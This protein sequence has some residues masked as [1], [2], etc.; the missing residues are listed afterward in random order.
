MSEK[1]RLDRL[2][3][4]DSTLHIVAYNIVYIIYTCPEAVNTVRILFILFILSCREIKSRIALSRSTISLEMNRVKQQ[5][6]SI[7]VEVAF[8]GTG[9]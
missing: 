4:T 9:L 3:R 7:Y 8:V 1:L 2:G 5:C 6:H